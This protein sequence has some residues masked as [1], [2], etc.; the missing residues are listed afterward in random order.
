MPS[1]LVDLTSDD[2]RVTIGVGS[3]ASSPPTLRPHHAGNRIEI[4]KFCCLGQNVTIFAGGNH[5]THHLTQHHLRLYLDLGDFEDWSQQCLDRDHV[6]SI[7]NDVW[8]G[9]GAIILTGV[10]VGDGAAIGARAVVSKDVPPYAI[11]AGNRAEIIRYRFEPDIIRQ[12][13]RL[14]WWDWPTPL[15]REAADILFSADIGALSHFAKSHNLGKARRTGP[16]TTAGQAGNA[17]SRR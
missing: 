3:W 8:I 11:V 2:P 15:L 14:K 12:L 16:R 17:R 10:K 5:P 9:D 7:G 4:G 6:T 1:W 13:E